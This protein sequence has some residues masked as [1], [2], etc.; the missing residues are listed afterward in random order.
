MA[1]PYD[2]GLLALPVP[3]LRPRVQ[4]AQLEDF[5]GPILDDLRAGRTLWADDAGD[6]PSLGQISP[7]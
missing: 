4:R 7:R 3:H 5:S 6:P 1:G 2:S